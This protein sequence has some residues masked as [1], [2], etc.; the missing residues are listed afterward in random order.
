[1]NVINIMNFI[2]DIDERVENSKEI[3]FNTT[4]KELEMVRKYGYK[5]TFLL[6]YDALLDEKYLN[7][8]KDCGDNVEFG[9]WYE[10]VRPLTES[11]G[12]PYDSKFGWIWD[13]HVKPGY[14]MSYPCDIRRKLIDEAMRKFKEVFGY[15][16][17]VV[18][19]W[20]ID[21]TTLNHLTDHY[22]IDMIAIC[23]DQY[24]TD[25]YNLIGGYY[26]AYYPS[27]NNILT[28][29]KGKTQ[30]N[31]PVFRLLGPCPLN[32]YDYGKYAQIYNEGCF[33]LEPVWP[34]GANPKYVDW[35][36]KTIF[37]NKQLG[38]SYAQI[39]QENCF[40]TR[41]FLPALEMQLEK[42]KD[43]D[44]VNILTM[45]ETGRLFKKEYKETPASAIYAIN[46]H[47]SGNVQALNYNSKYYTVGVL[48][49]ENKI[50]IRYLYLFD[51]NVKEH[52]YDKEC[53][54][55]FATYENLPII[56]T[57][58]TEIGVG[59]L[60]IDD[61]ASSFEVKHLS[62]DSVQITWNNG[63]IILE[64]S[65]IR[66]NKDSIQ[67]PKGFHS[68][69]NNR[70]QYEHDG[71]TYSIIIEGADIKENKDG[72]LVKAKNNQI[73]ISYDYK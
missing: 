10:I 23:R 22:D 4:K 46:D 53:E 11:I 34:C 1:M 65:L 12:V 57:L 73:T 20:V 49:Y 21:S 56:E 3:L 58:T 27:R 45:S 2:R 7:L 16:P 9:L 35:A 54:T 47:E 51:D 48:R 61:N 14:P 37:K 40:G 52:Y 8:F 42:I 70:V 32:N 64:P 17:K 18:A 59:N 19:S 33:T 68:I 60:S 71:H 69:K 5:S 36:F 67:L 31:V 66:I 62:K 13:W 50:F 55:F 39:G 24:N 6:Q 28:P 44:N 29:G 30:I 25:A 43:L 26:P 41:D 72:I 15:Y 63:S 38:W